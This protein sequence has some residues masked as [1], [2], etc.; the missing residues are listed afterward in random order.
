MR[1]Q[2][3]RIANLK[4][5]SVPAW[6][7]EQLYVSEFGEDKLELKIGHGCPIFKQTRR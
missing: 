4:P 3:F 5:L 7:P 6:T 2:F 1:E